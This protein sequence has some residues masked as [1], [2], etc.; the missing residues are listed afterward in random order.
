MNTFKIKCIISGRDTDGKVSVFEEAVA[1]KSGPPLHTHE[2]QHEIFHIISGDLQFEVDGKRVD[3]VAG[4]SIH[5]PPGV[6]H[7]FVNKSGTESIIHFELLPSGNS[8]QF[9]DKLVA[10]DFTDPEELFAQHGLKILGP[11]IS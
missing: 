3:L 8:E 9:F 4:G 6:P 10:G 11:P 1:A 7:T 5:V 2:T